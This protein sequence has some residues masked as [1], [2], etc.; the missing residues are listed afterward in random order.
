MTGSMD[1]S[2]YSI[3]RRARP[4][5]EPDLLDIYYQMIYSINHEGRGADGG[6]VP[7]AR[8]PGDGPAARR[9]SRAR[10]PAGPPDR[11]AGARG[12]GVAPAR[13]DAGDGLPGPRRARGPGR[14][15]EGGSRGDGR[16][17]R[18]RHRPPPPPGVRIGR[19]DRR[20]AGAGA[21]RPVAAGAARGGLRGEGVFDPVSRTMPRLPGARKEKAMKPWKEPGTLE[22]NPIGLER[23]ATAKMIKEL[24][25]HVASVMVLYHQYLKHHWLVEGP[26]FRD[27]HHFLGDRKSVV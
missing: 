7:G 3:R 5:G 4:R 10:R 25:A 11:R 26:Q 23:T 19:A 13:D 21:G 9:P 8:A 17:V 1:R 27:V 16:G 14:G 6:P 24:D 2:E 22:G 18:G 12:R 20:P 15:A